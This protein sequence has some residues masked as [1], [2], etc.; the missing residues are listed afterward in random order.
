MRGFSSDV[1]CRIAIMAH[2]IAPGM[3]G[4]CS[5]V[6]CRVAIMAHRIAPRMDSFSSD[7]ACR[8]AISP[9]PHCDY[10]APLCDS[11]YRLAIFP[12]FHT[13]APEF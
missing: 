4:F 8:V 10:S 1:A 9:L 3:G 6:A 11:F 13:F 5:D 2:R 7:V 12:F